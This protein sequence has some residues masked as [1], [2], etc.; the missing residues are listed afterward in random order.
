MHPYIAQEPDEL[1]LD[2]ADLLNVLE[3]TDDGMYPARDR[4]GSLERIAV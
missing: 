4:L 3:K 2:L 1:S